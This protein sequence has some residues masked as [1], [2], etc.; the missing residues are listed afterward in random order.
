MYHEIKLNN[1]KYSITS[2]YND[3]ELIESNTWIGHDGDT[4]DVD[5]SVMMSYSCII[6]I[7][8]WM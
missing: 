4:S 7:T 2:K 8:L 6:V 1:K 3:D 5:K